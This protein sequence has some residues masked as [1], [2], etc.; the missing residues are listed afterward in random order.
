MEAFYN[1]KTTHKR[2]SEKRGRKKGVIKMTI[3]KYGENVETRMMRE[4]EEER[5]KAERDKKPEDRFPH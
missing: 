1:L 3:K 5:R 4:A 2:K